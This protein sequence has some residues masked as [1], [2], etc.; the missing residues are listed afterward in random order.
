[1]TTT[2]TAN[3]NN[4]SGDLNGQTF[5]NDSIEEKRIEN[6]NNGE[7]KKKK[8]NGEKKDRIKEKKKKQNNTKALDALD[9]IR[10]KC[11]ELFVDQIGE[12]Y[13]AIKVRDHIETIAIRN[14]HFKDWIVKAY[15]DYRKEQQQKSL[16]AE[17]LDGK[18]ED[19]GT[20]EHTISP[21]PFLS[22]EDAAKIQTILKMEADEL[23]NERK[24]EVRVAGNVD[25]DPDANDDDNMIY[26]DLT[27]RDWEI[28]KITKHGWNIEKHGFLFLSSTSPT[29]LFK[30]Y[31]NQSTQVYPA[32]EYP[33]DIFSQFMDLTNLP[34]DDKENR[35]LAEVY[36]VA[37]FIPPDIPKT[38]LIP[39]GEQGAAKSTFQELIKTL[40]DP[41][42]A[43]TLS[44]PKDVAELVQQLS[45][46]YIAYYD[47]V[48][49]IPQWISDLLCR[50]VTG[51]GFSKRVLYSDDDDFIY[52]FRRCV[53]FNGINVGSNKTR[54]FGERTDL[55]FKT[56]SERKET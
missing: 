1:M 15:Y 55:T 26:Y 40:V 44:F 34:A 8:N 18:E 54:P 43:L 29:I 39:H 20:I 36:T 49:E 23:H 52:R 10:S 31:K 17:E 16:D 5:G 33:P 42:G 7:G 6:D 45:H 53:G 47:N 3:D 51:S 13:A 37:L 50:A 35:I 46:N 11:L 22:I 30:R 27:N 19:N 32:K 4:D 56:Y 12:P 48:S 28:V 21:S 9:V 24:L 14:N 25:S 41:C 38:V 2:S